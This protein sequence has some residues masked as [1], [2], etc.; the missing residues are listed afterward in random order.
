MRRID[1]P[2]PTA[3][4]F[5][6]AVTKRGA[7]HLDEMSDMVAEGC[8]AVMFYLVQRDDCDHFR[9]AADID[10]YY[11]ETLASAR[12]AGVEAICYT[13]RLSLEGIE[14]DA[15]LPLALD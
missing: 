2:H 4:E 3:A 13:C 9:I 14:L 15:P 6:D 5:P 8:R 12:K 7:K 1:G 10:P 11:A